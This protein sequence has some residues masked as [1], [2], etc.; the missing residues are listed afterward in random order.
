MTG[1]LWQRYGAAGSQA[2][3]SQQRPPTACGSLCIQAE[4]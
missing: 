4:P 1:R 2:E 3:L